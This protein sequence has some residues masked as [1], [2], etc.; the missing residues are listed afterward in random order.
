[1][2]YTMSEAV[3][4]YIKEVSKT[5]E[6]Q[7]DFFPK[8]MINVIQQQRDNFIYNEM[9]N[10]ISCNLGMAVDINKD[11]LKRWVNMCIHLENI[12]ND[13][14][15]DIAIKHK[16]NKLEAENER[17]KSEIDYLN[18]VIIDFVKWKGEE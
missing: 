15:V 3:K 17:L 13:E 4:K 14:R 11:K 10:S 12:P 7:N 6:E 16:I 5:L 18:E 2:K 1:M 9:L 8:D